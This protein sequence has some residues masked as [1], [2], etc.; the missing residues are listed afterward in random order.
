MQGSSMEKI[1]VLMVIVGSHKLDF[2]QFISKI[3]LNNGE[4]FSFLI[5]QL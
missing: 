4:L 2:K 3:N 1:N 5:K